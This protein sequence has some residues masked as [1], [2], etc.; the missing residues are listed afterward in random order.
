[1]EERRIQGR[2]CF[3]Y[4]CGSA[5]TLLI[6]P[7]GEHNLETMEHEVDLIRQLSKGRP[8]TMAMFLVDWNKDLPPWKAEPVRGEEPFGCGALETLAFIE[9]D[10]IPEVIDAKA[11]EIY[12][13]GYSLAGLFSLWAA[14]QTDRF[15]GVAAASP[16]VWYP[17]FPAFAKEHDIKAP[18]VYL[19]L[20]T[21]EEKTRH[22]VMKT[23]GENI[24]GLYALLDKSSWESILEM[25]PGNHF[26]EPDLRMAKAFAWLIEKTKQDFHNSAEDAYI[27]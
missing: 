19:S 16:F 7:I 11:P 17:D 25:N 12:L 18:R 3:I 20:G 24:R 2:R 5:D 21:K 6:Q 8:F 23:V 15:A 10:L 1:M 4:D 27:G 26:K 14:Y 22:P 13:G 9:E